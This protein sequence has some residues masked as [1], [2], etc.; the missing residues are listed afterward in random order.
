M[1]DGLLP[2]RLPAADAGSVKE[3]KLLDLLDDLGLEPLQVLEVGALDLA[4]V[5]KV[6]EGDVL[7]MCRRLVVILM[8]GR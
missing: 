6:D 2:L 3:V 5:V 7:L 1:C 8:G 4:V